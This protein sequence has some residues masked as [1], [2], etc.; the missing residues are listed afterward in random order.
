MLNELISLASRPDSVYLVIDWV[1]GYTIFTTTCR[2]THLWKELTSTERAM[3]AAG[4]GLGLEISL[5]VPLYLL[6]YYL[7]GNPKALDTAIIE[8]SILFGGLSILI[9]LFLRANGASEKWIRE[10]L[11]TFLRRWVQGAWLLFIAGSNI[12]LLSSLYPT[13]IQNFVIAYSGFFLAYSVVAFAFSTVA[14]FITENLYLLPL[15]G[16]SLIRKKNHNARAAPLTSQ[17]MT[18]FQNFIHSRSWIYPIAIVL[19]I[20]STVA[21]DLRYNIFTPGATEHEESFNQPG[22]WGGPNMV[23][24]RIYLAYQDRTAPHADINS[25]LTSYYQLATKRYEITRPLIPISPPALLDLRITL[26]TNAS[27]KE[28]VTYHDSNSLDEVWIKTGENITHKFVADNKILRNL[29]IQLQPASGNRTF[30]L[31]VTYSYEFKARKVDLAVL[32][33]HT[34]LGNN[35][36]LE[37]YILLVTN[38]EPGMLFLRDMRFPRLNYEAVDL[39]TAKFYYNGKVADAFRAD[40]LVVN[41]GLDIKPNTPTQNI[42]MTIIAHY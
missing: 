25:G 35:T 13:T 24:S 33:D 16:N 30:D 19:I 11:W 42:T 9:P 28:A 26:P 40:R 18:G 36:R 15:S 23:T 10:K 5:A 41:F 17:M 39:S 2:K 6:I 27:M 29:L 20:T 14:R 1:A 34:N 37:R 38:R 8:S 31:N 7:L 32:T 22:Y 3:I 21:L 12:I 4:F